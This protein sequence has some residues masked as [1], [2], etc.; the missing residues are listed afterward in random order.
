MK[1]FV[2]IICFLFVL[3]SFMLA[4]PS[5]NFTNVHDG[6]VISSTNTVL[7]IEAKAIDSTIYWIDVMI[8]CPP[9]AAY[10]SLAHESY[11]FEDGISN[12]SA[13]VPVLGY[14][15]ACELRLLANLF[16]GSE[17]DFEQKSDYADIIIEDEGHFYSDD[18]DVIVTRA[19]SKTFYPGS[20]LSTVYVITPQEDFTGLIIKDYYPEGVQYTGSVLSGAALKNVAQTHDAETREVKFAV[21]DS[22]KIPSGSL[23]AIYLVTGEFEPGDELDFTGTWETLNDNGTILGYTT[24]ASGFDMP[25]CPLTDTQLLQYFDDWA[26]QKLDPN[27][28]GK[29]DEVIQNIIEVWKNC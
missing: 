16:K 2:L 18:K 8:K 10:Q 3:I 21:S 23:R 19:Y 15:G 25:A 4:E 6:D 24:Y 26:Q 29:N 11:S 27:S 14:D 1:K 28:L 12:F 5:I 9:T 13:Y 20:I 22:D 7:N 17:N